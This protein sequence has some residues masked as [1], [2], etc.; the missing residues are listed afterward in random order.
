MKQWPCWSCVVKCCQQQFLRSYQYYQTVIDMQGSHISV[1]V[2]RTIRVLL[3]DCSGRELFLQIVVF[4]R[5]LQLVVASQEFSADKDL[6]HR[7]LSRNAGEGSLHSG[8]VFLLV[9]V[10]DCNVDVLEFVL[11]QQRLGLVAVAAP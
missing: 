10:V 11:A 9:N 6:W 3:L 2:A 1:H 7:R 4:V 5:F 8:A